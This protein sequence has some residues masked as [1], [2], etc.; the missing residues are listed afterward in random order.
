MS[1][2]TAVALAPGFS[3]RP[4]PLKA[5]TAFEFRKAQF[6]WYTKLVAR[7]SLPGMRR[8]LCTATSSDRG[9]S[10]RPEPLKACTALKFCK[11]QFAWYAKLVARFRLS[12]VRSSVRLV[13]E[14][15]GTPLLVTK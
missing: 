3:R 13:C 15:H 4:E 14:G 9:F 2:A 8:R 5:C 1:W 7:L 11:A 10:F 12:G 6:A